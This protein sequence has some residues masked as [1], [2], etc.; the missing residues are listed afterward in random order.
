MFK[1]A[2]LAS[3][4]GTD[5]QSVI[6]AVESK[7]INAKI[8]MVIGSKE[9]IYALERAKKHNIDTFVVSRKEYKEKS[10]DK[11]L[12]LT[13]GKVDLIV[14]AGFLSILD[15]KIL[16]EFEGKIINIHPSLIPSFCGP[17][18]YGLKVHEAVIKSGVKFSGCTV[19][20]VNSEVDGGAIILQEAVPVYFEDDAETLQKR[21]LE[22]EHIILPKA[23]KLLSEGKVKVS[24]GRVKIEE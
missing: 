3:G 13:K 24:D 18:M 14:L 5:L 9:G 16:K 6:D 21:I 11:I 17:N 10:S 12:E 1:I 4:G 2:V 19:H 8:E 22:K 15:G 23:I 20:F 7:Y